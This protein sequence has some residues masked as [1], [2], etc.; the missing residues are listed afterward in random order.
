MSAKITREIL[1]GYLNC[2]YKGNLRLTGAS[3][4]TSDY[5]LM[6]KE[7]RVWVRKDA[8]AKLIHEKKC[9]FLL[10][11]TATFDLLM[12]G[13]P[14]LLGATVENEQLKIRFDGLLQST[15]ASKLGDFHYI[16]ILIHEG[17]RLGKEQKALLELLALVL[18]DVQ[19]HE[20]LWGII[21]HGRNCN[22]HKVKLSRGYALAQR[23]LQQIK[24]MRKTDTPPKLRLNPHCQICEFCQ[25]C[26]TE[27]MAKDDL[28]LLRGMGEKELSKYNRRGIFTV[29]QMSC[30]FRP[31]RCASG[32]KQKERPHQHAL[33]ALAIRDKKIYVLGSP[34]LPNSAV[35]IFF[36][37][38]GDP[39]RGFDYLLGLIIEIGGIEKHYSFWA[40]SPAEEHFVFQQ[41]LAIVS[42]HQDFSLY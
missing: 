28:S 20:P 38:E 4:I 37:V 42:E 32:P 1:E 39:E 40:D 10:D 31:K 2:R 9:D 12:R 30:T 25:R 24:V 22:V 36:D 17:E 8:A 3:G 15:G 26:H 35:R 29:T 16:P 11:V 7:S 5:E 13:V 23:T 34:E 33:Q 18:A 27:A 6:L 14:L 19:G 21:I 41:F